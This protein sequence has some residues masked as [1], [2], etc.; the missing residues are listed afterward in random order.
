[1]YT[2]HIRHV[3]KQCVRL[4]YNL[5]SEENEVGPDSRQVPVVVF[6]EHN[7][8]PTYSRQRECTF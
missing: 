5:H 2:V 4:L 3:A 8:G 6:M 1:M 7:V